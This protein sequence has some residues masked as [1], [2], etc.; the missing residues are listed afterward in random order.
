ML[1][2]SKTGQADEV[3]E[4][5][6]SSNGY[7]YEAAEVIACLRAGKTESDIMPLNETLSILK[8]ADEVRAEWGLKYPVE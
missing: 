1:T 8:T 2:L 7:N 6:Y 4:L 5:P 3:V